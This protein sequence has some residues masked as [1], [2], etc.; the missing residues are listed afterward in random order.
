VLEIPVPLRLIVTE[1]SSGSLEGIFE[2]LENVPPD[3]G[4][5]RY[6]MIQ[7]TP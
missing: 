4:K 1:L 2:L 3:E 6:I 5:N 7:A